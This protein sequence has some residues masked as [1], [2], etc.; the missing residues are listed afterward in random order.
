[1][2]LSKPIALPRSPARYRFV[3]TPLADAM[4]QLLIFFMLSSNLAPYS[5]LTI[6]SGAA[7]NPEGG[8]NG[9]EEP[10]PEAAAPIG[11]VA[12]WNV[13]AGNVLI[14]GQQFGFELL[15]DLAAASNVDGDAAIILVVR[16]EATVQD[17][18]SVLEALSAGG[19][20]NIQIAGGPS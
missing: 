2:A 8:E 20:T 9:A 13:A 17:L 12:I 18:S 10:A 4:F 5:L 6:R 3:L 16:D 14:G 7:G 11:E 19:I 15:A 1:M